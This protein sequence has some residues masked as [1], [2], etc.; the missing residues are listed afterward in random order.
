M[1]KRETASDGPAARYCRE[2][3]FTSPV[4]LSLWLFGP[5][6]HRR[7]SMTPSPAERASEDAPAFNG[8]EKQF[9]IAS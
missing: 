9:G 8:V 3:E 1:R 5:I 4:R 7:K 2:L 6:P